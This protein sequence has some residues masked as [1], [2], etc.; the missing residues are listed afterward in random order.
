MHT[1]T[2][3]MNVL[4]VIN[5]VNGG[6]IAANTIFGIILIEHLNLFAAGIGV[7]V[8][9]TANLGRIAQSIAHM[10]AIRRNGWLPINTPDQEQDS[11]E[12]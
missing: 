9:I 5:W 7:F 3:R 12:Q 11:K 10:N 2:T 8:T 6:L 4:P 1:T